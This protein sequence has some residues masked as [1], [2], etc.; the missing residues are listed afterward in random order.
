MNHTYVGLRN[1][2]FSKLQK[3]QK[4]D[5]LLNMQGNKEVKKTIE[6]LKIDINRIETGL[7]QC[8]NECTLLENADIICTTLN[9]CCALS[10]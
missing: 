3:Q 5:K 4:L 7:K 8:V 6:A 10:K 9:S 2:F 1:I